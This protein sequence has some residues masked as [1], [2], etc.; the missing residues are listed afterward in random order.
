M[1]TAHASRAAGSLIPVGMFL[2]LTIV[3]SFQP[4][5]RVQSSLALE[6]FRI[7]AGNVEEGGV[8]MGGSRSRTSFNLQPIVHDYIL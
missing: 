7:V 8:E 3:C 1:H 6:R 4:R 5:V 2:E